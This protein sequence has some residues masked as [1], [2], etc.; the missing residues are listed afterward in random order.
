MC[1]GEGC[2]DV[3]GLTGL[4]CCSEEVRTWDERERR[5]RYALELF[6]ASPRAR[7]SEG[8]SSLEKGSERGRRERLAGALSRRVVV[9]TCSAETKR[10][11]DADMSQVEVSATKRSSFATTRNIPVQHRPFWSPVRVRSCAHQSIAPSVQNVPVV[12]VRAKIAVVNALCS[13][14]NVAPCVMD[15]PGKPRVRVKDCLPLSG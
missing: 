5:R 13:V 2:G 15:P 11:R 7:E 1:G 10:P 4:D 6:L 14:T 3:T 12:C 9:E 8:R